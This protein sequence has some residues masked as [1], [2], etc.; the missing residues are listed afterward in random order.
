MTL[1][2]AFCPLGAGRG[3]EAPVGV[4]RHLVKVEDDC[5]RMAGLS[6]H[7]T[8]LSDLPDTRSMRS[9]R[10]LQMP[11]WGYEFFADAPPIEPEVVEGEKRHLIEVLCAYLETLQT[12][13]QL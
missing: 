2:Y 1:G 10:A 4:A 11:V 13:R 12:E 6:E 9:S 3:K 8:Q 5:R 7:R